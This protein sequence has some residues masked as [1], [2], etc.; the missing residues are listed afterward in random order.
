MKKKN[1]YLAIAIAIFNISFA[2]TGNVGIDTP[3]PASKLTVNGNMSAGAPS[4]NNIVAPANGAII[5]GNVGIGTTTP[6]AKLDVIGKIKITDGTEG[7]SKIFVSDANGTGSWSPAIQG[8]LVLIN[9]APQNVLN[10]PVGGIDYPKNFESIL[11]TI[12]GANYDSSADVVTLPAGTYEV[13]ISFEF[14]TT[15]GGTCPAPIPPSTISP[16]VNSYFMDFWDS[17]NP[18]GFQEVYCNTMAAC[19]AAGTH[20]AFWK[21]A[22]TIDTA[23]NFTVQIGRG[24]SGTYNNA[25]VL[26]PNS[27]ITYKRIL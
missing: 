14:Q 2:Q 11:N 7:A 13:S 16:V 4:F 6:A 24:H 9:T 25:V 27:T 22:F 8:V 10:V 20:P 15:L 26:A 21:T 5:Q 18:V 1:Y 19:G 17:N 12:Q 23:R 3:T